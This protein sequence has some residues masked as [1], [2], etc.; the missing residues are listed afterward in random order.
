MFSKRL[1]LFAALLF[2]SFFLKSQ[3]TVSGSLTD[4]MSGETLIG[5]SVELPSLKRGTTSNEYGFYVLTVPS[6]A[7]S[8]VLKFSYLGFETVFFKIKPTGAAVKL[9]VALSPSGAKLAEVVIRADEFEQKLTTTEM[10]T[11][12]LEV[13]DIKLIPVVFGESDIL[14]ALQLKPGFTPGTEGTTGLF[15]RGGAGDQNLIVLDEAIVYNPNH[16]FGFFSTFNSDAIKDLKVWKGGFPAQY[17]GRLSSVIDVRMKEGNNQSLNAEGG[18]GLIASRLTVEGPIQKDKSSFIVSGRRTY[19]DIFTRQVNKANEDNANFNQIPDYHFYDLNTKV[20]FKLTEKDHLF[21]SGY[22]GRDVFEFNSDQF[23]FDFDW[24]NATGTARLNHIYNARLFSNTT[25]TFSDYQ[26]KIQNKI[27]GFSFKT[28]SKIRD[29]NLKHDFYFAPNERHTMRFGAAATYHDFIVAR[30]KAGSDDGKISFNAGQNFDGVELAAYFSDEWKTTDRLSLNY[31]LRVSGFSN[32]I[33]KKDPNS[34][35]EPAFYG[36]IEPRLAANFAATDRLS[37][38]ASYARMQQYVHLISSS[39]ISLPTDVWYPSSKRVKPEASDQ[40]AVGGAFLLKKG[41]FFTA[42]AYYKWLHRQVELVDGA[43]IF[44]NDNL[45]NEF[46]FGR[47]YATG[48]ELELE[49]KSG[50]LTGWIGYQLAVTKRGGFPAELINDGK[51]FPTNYDTRHIVNVVSIYNLRRR[52]SL[53]ATFTYQSG[54]AKWLPAGRYTFQGTSGETFTAIVPLY[55][56]RNSFRMPYYLRADVGVVWKFFP[57]WG[58]SDLTFSIYNATNRRNPFFL[59]LDATYA[60]IDAGNGQTAEVPNGIQA[61]Q[62]SLFP[63]LPTVT[64]N[65]AFGKAKKN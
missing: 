13:R 34:P 62:V 23:N 5:A 38:K 35:A 19:V 26:Y 12:T 45:E 9:N 43:N 49:K 27:T 28:D 4:Q 31:G 1:P 39:G 63:V 17:G 16:L 55:G 21:V 8:V 52:L 53:S 2:S 57:K 7:D 24:G 10:S 22:F 32:K 58:T 56:E 65:F 18:I 54:Y 64:W 25:F 48:L 50:K 36:G 14:K 3:T 47:G 59:F 33:G 6:G 46:A 11:T 44:A 20:N 30:L 15:V 42:E 51:F 61:K 60:T 37:W 41:L 40:I 29:I